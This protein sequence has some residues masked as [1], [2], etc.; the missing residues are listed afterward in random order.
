MKVF[1][2]KTSKIEGL[3]RLDP[4]YYKPEYLELVEKVRALVPKKVSDVFRIELGPAYSSRKIGVKHGIKVAKIGDV[5]NKRKVEDWALL[6]EIEFKKYGCRS[7]KQNEI[8][9]TLTGDPPDVGKTFMPA[10]FCSTSQL[11]IA[12]NQRVAKLQSKS[13]SPYYLYAFLSSE[14]FRIRFE[15]VALGIRQRNVSVPD[16]LNAFVYVPDDINVIQEISEIVK[17]HFELAN[18]YEDLYGEAND[19]LSHSLAFE[20]IKFSTEKTFVSSFSNVVVSHRL[21]AQHYKVK[22]NQLFDHLNTRFK[23]VRIGDIETLNRRGIQ[24]AY[25]KDGEI[26]I[27][28]SEH[29]GETHLDYEKLAKT[30]TA[31]FQKHPEAHI[32]Y[33]DV[34]IYTTGAFVGRTSVYLKDQPAFASNHVNVL[35][36]KVDLD[37]SYLALLLNSIVGKFQTE[38]Y[39]RGSAQAELYPHDIAKFTIPLIDK[40]I[41]AE[42]GDKVRKSL[43]AKEQSK[44]LYEK[45]KLLVEKIIDQS[46]RNINKQMVKQV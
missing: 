25:Y 26:D 34:L 10:P 30:T 28:N 39:Q 9:I 11:P 38:K 1:E 5:T 45:A 13:V 7:I 18:E 19:L 29:I 16:L 35:R 27:V 42:I 6:D 14:Y 8:L 20:D 40:K 4:E 41:M 15:Q 44:A 31:F 23:C 36:L 37:P 24:P 33:N 3:T 21:D 2:I 43:L 22:Y 46:K 32:R 17:R 12:F